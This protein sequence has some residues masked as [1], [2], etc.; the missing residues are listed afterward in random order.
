MPAVI[1]I[2]GPL[3]LVAMLG[4][5]SARNEIFTREQIQGFGIFVVKFGLPAVLVSSL[6]N[7]NISQIFNV[8]LLCAYL[9]V[10]FP[11]AF[12][13]WIIVWR[14]RGREGRTATTLALSVAIPNSVILGFPLMRQVFGDAN[15]NVFLSAVLLENAFYLPLGYVVYEWSA[16][17][18]PISLR[19][20]W[21]IFYRVVTTPITFSVIFGLA[22][23]LMEVSIPSLFADG[24]SV[25]SRSVLGLA[26]FYVGATLATTQVRIVNGYVLSS[27]M[28][29]LAVAPCLAFAVGSIFP[30]IAPDDRSMMVLFA[31]LPCFTSL[32]AIASPYGTA[33]LAAS[34]QVI[35]TGLSVLTLP[36]VI[37]FLL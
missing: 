15:L 11:I 9:F 3:I 35:G 31:A 24:L 34:V 8:R 29:R 7:V 17:D 5:I 1:S 22:L 33:P 36:I 26:L 23:S 10:G 30:G 20:I 13:F 4:F 28:L 37:W 21:S 16:H 18:G 32:P 19:S 25:V 6:V 12:L 14:I 27:L 2:V